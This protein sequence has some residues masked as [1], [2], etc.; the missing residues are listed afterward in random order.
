MKSNQN[1]SS[2]V[3]TRELVLKS[4]IFK[5]P[6]PINEDELPK[7]KFPIG[8]YRLH[9]EPEK[10][11]KELSKKNTIPNVKVT[12]LI[13]KLT[14]IISSY[15]HS[16]EDHKEEIINELL[17]DF[18]KDLS[19][20]RITK[21]ETQEIIKKYDIKKKFINSDAFENKKADKRYYNLCV[22]LFQVFRRHLNINP[23][24]TLYY[25][26]HLLV[27]C[28]LEKLTANKAYGRIKKFIERYEE[29]NLHMKTYRKNPVK[30]IF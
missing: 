14:R 13:S 3:P 18:E 30:T 17:D 24:N 4:G 26:A 6:E 1:T 12:T 29:E 9:K 2:Y 11:H 7:D 10:N 28:G 22:P 27:D 5:H 20:Y 23:E 15:R 8:V 21:K 19:K 25:M 16:P